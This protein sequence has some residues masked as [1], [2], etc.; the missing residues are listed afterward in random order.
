MIGKPPVD[1]EPVVGNVV[2]VSKPVNQKP[3]KLQV[4]DYET[5]D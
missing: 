2:H 3:N 4:L 1:D 5:G